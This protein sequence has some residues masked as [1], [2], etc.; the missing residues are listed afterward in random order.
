MK[1]NVAIK[2]ANTDMRKR[3]KQCTAE[4]YSELREKATAWVN[5]RCNNGNTTLEGLRQCYEWRDAYIV[6]CK[7]TYMSVPKSVFNTI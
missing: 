3:F 7:G 2:A 5:K 4:H 6:L 1:N